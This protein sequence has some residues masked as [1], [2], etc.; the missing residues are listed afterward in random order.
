MPGSELGAAAQDCDPVLL[1]VK[2]TGKNVTNLSTTARYDDSHWLTLA[3]VSSTRRVGIA[4]TRRTRL[5]LLEPKPQN[6][7][8]SGK[9]ENVLHLGLAG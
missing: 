2:V 7:Y 3:V 8:G 5:F 1:L 9:A 6:G 4:A